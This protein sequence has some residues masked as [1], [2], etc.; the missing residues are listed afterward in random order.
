MTV[1]F[2]SIESTLSDLETE[3]D[4]ARTDIGDARQEQ[5]DAAARIAY[6]EDY[7]GVWAAG[8][9][10]V[11][12]VVFHAENFYE[13]DQARTSARIRSNPTVNTTAW[14][15]IQSL[16]QGQAET[17]LGLTQAVQD[18]IDAQAQGHI[19]NRLPGNVGGGRSCR[20]RCHLLDWEV[21]PLHRQ[22]ATH[23]HRRSGNRYRELGAYRNG[24]S[25]DH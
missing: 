20:R 7:Q 25:G 5:I 4:S 12:D 18:T 3:L 14:S 13:C 11:G 2:S 21:L 6:G 23:G 16:K 24:H 10:A 17:M 1:D 15:I 8:N 19:W 22:E 9:F